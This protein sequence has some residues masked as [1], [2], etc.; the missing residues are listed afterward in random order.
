MNINMQQSSAP[1]SLWVWLLAVDEDLGI[2]LWTGFGNH[3]T[4]PTSIGQQQQQSSSCDGKLG[5]KSIS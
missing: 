2:C 1:H 5:F 3:I 4:Y